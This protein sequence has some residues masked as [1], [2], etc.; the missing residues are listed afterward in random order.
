M[1]FQYFCLIE[2]CTI[3]VLSHVAVLA[4]RHLAI[5]ARVSKLG[6]FNFKEGLQLIEAHKSPNIFFGMPLVPSGPWA[7]RVGGWLQL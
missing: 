7:G 5:L 3:K 1:Q 2:F 4:C 6:Y